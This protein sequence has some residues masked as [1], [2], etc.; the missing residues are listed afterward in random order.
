MTIIKYVLKYSFK[1]IPLTNTQIINGL[2]IKQKII[3]TFSSKIFG[4][5]KINTYLR[6]RNQE[7]NA[8]QV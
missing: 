5:L 6:T 1:K 4:R 8:T 3:F 2:K 7:M